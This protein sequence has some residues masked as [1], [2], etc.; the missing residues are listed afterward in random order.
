MTIID[1]L[2]TLGW[3]L[4][5]FWTFQVKGVKKAFTGISTFFSIIALFALILEPNPI[6]NIMISV[7]LG[8]ISGIFTG[9]AY[10]IGAN[11]SR[12]RQFGKL[13]PRIIIYIVIFAI[14]AGLEIKY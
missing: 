6:A 7:G 1:F 10:L 5:G 2:W 8:F 4:V 12:F 11:I 9:L 13:S 14:W 3:F